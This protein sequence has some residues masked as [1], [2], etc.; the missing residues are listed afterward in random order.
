MADTDWDA[1]ING[2][3]DQITQMQQVITAQQM[4]ITQGEQA[5]AQ[6][7]S[8]ITQWA[9]LA[10]AISRKVQTLNDPG[11]Y[12]RDRAKFHEWWTKMKVWIRAHDTVLTLNFDKCTAVW[13]RM[14]GP[15]AGRYAANRMNECMDR[16]IWPDWGILSNEIE[17][18]F[19][20]QTNVEWSRQELCKLKQGFMRIEDFINKFMSLKQQGN[21]SDD[22]ACALL[23][24][25]IRPELLREVLLTNCN[26]SDWDDFSQCVLKMG[27]NLERLQIIG[28]GY[29]PGYNNPAGSS[30]FSA[31]GTQPSAGTPMNISAAQQQQRA[32][33]P[34]CYNCQQFGHIARNCRN[35]KV[36]QGQ[37][38]QTA[39]VAEIPTQQT[40][41]PSNDERIRALQ[42]MD[43]KA[44]KAYF[45]DLKG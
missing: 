20:P 44:M 35:K 18:H 33:N 3:R 2:L 10:N 43:F 45:A 4:Q 41:G 25:A 1:I 8:G 29:T 21:V 31:T 40:A 32:G 30:H 14:E 34:Q 6:V 42:G 23:E 19:S 7:Q 11:T 17:A 5:M 22:F 36:P 38:P 26:M 28:G 37:A 24:Q 9:I 12:T 39:R 27:R 15:I 13:S 16:G